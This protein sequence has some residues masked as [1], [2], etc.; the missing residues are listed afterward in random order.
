MSAGAKIYSPTK[1][2]LDGFDGEHYEW[3]WDKDKA[4]SIRFSEWESR[5]NAVKKE[6]PDATITVP[7]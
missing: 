1:G 5:L 6:T 7:Q 3:T 4:W 2:W